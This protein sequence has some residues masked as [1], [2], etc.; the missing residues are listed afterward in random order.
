MSVTL[1]ILPRSRD[2]QQYEVTA[3]NNDAL[4]IRQLDDP[5][6]G[7]LK[8]ASCRWNRCS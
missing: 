2:G 5:N 4:T 3:I 1:Y 7:G 8:S 6:G